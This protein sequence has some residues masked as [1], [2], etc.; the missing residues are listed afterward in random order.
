IEVVHERHE[1]V[2]GG[3]SHVGQSTIEARTVELDLSQCETEKQSRAGQVTAVAALY[4]LEPDV[5]DEVGF[6]EGLARQTT[7]HVAEQLLNVLPALAADQTSRR[8]AH[9][10]RQRAAMGIGDGRA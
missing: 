3:V 8:L 2:G 9:G 7:S 6:A 10:G 1:L 5:D 4:R